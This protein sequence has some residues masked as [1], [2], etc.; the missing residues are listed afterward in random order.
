[1]S[2]HRKGGI[3]ACGIALALISDCLFTT[4]NGEP[5][6]EGSLYRAPETHPFDSRPSGVGPKI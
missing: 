6:G 5:I 1:V 3:T 2:D 4:E